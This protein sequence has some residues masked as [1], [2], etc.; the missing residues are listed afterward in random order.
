MLTYNQAAP[1]QPVLLTSQKE[2]FWPMLSQYCK[3]SWQE[4]KDKILG[5]VPDAIKEVSS[6]TCWWF[7][8]PTAGDVTESGWQ[9]T[10]ADTNVGMAHPYT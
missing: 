5:Q 4:V 6:W 7:M 1:V 9:E 3:A 8:H 10:N 2:L